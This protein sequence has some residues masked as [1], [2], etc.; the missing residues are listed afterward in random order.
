MMRLTSFA[1]YMGAALA[2]PM[3]WVG[4]YTESM[5]GEGLNVCVDEVDGDY[6]G[7]GLLSSL[8]Y[9]RG[10]IQGNVWAGDYWLAGYEGRMGTFYLD[11]DV[12]GST[13]SGYFTENPGQNITS[14]GTRTSSSMPDDIEC[15]RTHKDYLVPHAS[16]DI[17]GYYIKPGMPTENWWIYNDGSYHTSTYTYTE[18]SI[19]GTSYGPFY[20]NGQVSIDNWYESAQD[21]GI[22]LIVAKNDTAF[23]NLW[24][25][26]SRVSDVDYSTK[27]DD[28]FGININILDPSVTG[29]ELTELAESGKC[30]A[31]WTEDMEEAC[32]ETDSDDDNQDH[33]LITELLAALLVF[34][35]IG[36]ILMGVMLYILVSKPKESLASQGSSA[37][38]SSKL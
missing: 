8:G 37:S 28:N 31:L 12:V 30:Y 1:V 13:Y 15:F 20:L 27:L 26:A 23:Y 3:D 21:E 19:P 18:D 34:S 36:L 10:Y 5:Y 6:V 14:S 35:I 24:W 33:E 25:F 7:Q 29:S 22:E 9:M 16:Y 4:M 2:A 11:L 17:T 38:S 32:R